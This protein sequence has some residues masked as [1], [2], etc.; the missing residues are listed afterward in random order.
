MPPS[1]SKSPTLREFDY[2]APALSLNALRARSLSSERPDNAALMHLKSLIDPKGI[3]TLEPC[4]QDNVAGWQIEIAYD[5]VRRS[6]EAIDK[7]SGQPVPFT[8]AYWFA[9]QACYFKNG[10][11]QRPSWEKNCMSKGA[12]IIL[13]AGDTHESLRRV[14][15][16]FMGALEYIERTSPPLWS[17]DVPYFRVMSL[18]KGYE[19]YA[20]DQDWGLPTPRSKTWKW[21]APPQPIAAITRFALR[22]GL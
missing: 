16:A 15:N 14:V 22:G 10:T 6:A 9:W 13:A 20:L 11:V 18:V 8:M 5:S 7:Q 1:R 4:V 12:F 21:P 19:F 2:V 3:P 17:V